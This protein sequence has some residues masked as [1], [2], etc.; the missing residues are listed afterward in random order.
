MLARANARL[1][2]ITSTSSS[3]ISRMF[4]T[5]SSIGD[6]GGPREPEGRPGAR[7]GFDP[8]L[9]T[10]R[11][12]DLAH[13]GQT[14]SC[15]LDL[16]ASFEGLEQTPDTI[17]KLRR[18]AHAVVL[19]VERPDIAGALAT[20]LDREL[21]VRVVLDGVGDEVEDDLLQRHPR[22]TQRR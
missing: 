2:V 1:T 6:L 17:V 12:D 11:F 21:A 3:S 8:S 4:I 22:R 7:R 18:D 19:H 10:A 5:R 9:A 13:D 20:D 14:N 16:V 15:A